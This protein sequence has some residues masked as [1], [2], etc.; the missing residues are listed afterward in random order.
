MPAEL[1]DVPAVRRLL[2]GLVSSVEKLEIVCYARAHADERWSVADAAVQLGLPRLELEDAVEEL[3]RA[4]LF[5]RDAH[6]YRIIARAVAPGSPVD[7]L[8][9]MYEADRGRVL[10]VMNGLVMER[11]RMSAA[12]AF[13]RPRP[14]RR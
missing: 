4:G 13:S 10:A 14:A 3:C 9:R 6:R 7:S 2:A 1:E 5:E 11:L 12:V 8:S